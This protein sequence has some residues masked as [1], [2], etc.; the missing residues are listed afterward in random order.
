MAPHRKLIERLIQKGETAK[1]MGHLLNQARRS[2]LGQIIPTVLGAVL[3]S[4]GPNLF[5]K[6]GHANSIL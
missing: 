3:C 1:R 4:L 2:I 6:L 5:S